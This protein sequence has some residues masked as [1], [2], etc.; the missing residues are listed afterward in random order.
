MSPVIWL[1]ERQCRKHHPERAWN[2]LEMGIAATSATEIL[3][4]RGWR[5]KRFRVIFPAPNYLVT[6]ESP[7]ISTKQ[8]D[9][10]C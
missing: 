9:E 3:F 7:G 5:Y 1:S 10:E 4:P 2:G 8:G 6:K